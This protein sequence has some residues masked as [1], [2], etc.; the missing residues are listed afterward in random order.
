MQKRLGV[1]TS[2]TVALLPVVVVG[3]CAVGVPDVG[4]SDV[5]VSI[6]GVSD[7]RTAVAVGKNGRP[8]GTVVAATGAPNM[9]STAG[10]SD[11]VAERCA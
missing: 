11:D 9:A 6:E 2:A 3:A 4:V 7:T 1:D 10:V 8:A 5:G